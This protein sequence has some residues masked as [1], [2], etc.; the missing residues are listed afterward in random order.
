[1]NTPE[2]FFGGKIA[3]FINQWEMLTSDSW[4][5]DIVKGYKIEF[6]QLPFQQNLPNSIHFNT[7]E[8]NI[9]R[10]EIQKLLHKEVIE[11]TTPCFKNFISNICVR[12]KA[13]GTHRLIL[14]LKYLNED[15]EHIHF[16][17]ET[18]KSVLPIIKRNSWYASVDLKDAYYSVP[19]DK[20]FRKYLCFYWE[21]SLYRFTSLPNGLSSAP[22]VFTKLMKPVFSH[23]R[24][25]GYTNICYIDDILLQGDTYEE[26]LEN[27]TQ[28]TQLVD[29]LGLTIHP[30]KS[31]FEPC[32][33]ITFLGFIINS[34]DMTIRL[35][36]EKAKELSDLCN[37]LSK[38]AEITIRELAQVIGKMVA[39]ESGMEYG[40]LY[41]KSLE[42]EKDKKLKENCGNFEAKIQISNSAKCSLN[43]WSNNIQLCF[44]SLILSEPDIVIKTDS[45]K[46]GWGGVVENT[47]LKTGGFW[48]YEEQQHH[49]NFLE[50]KAA[51]LTIQSFLSTDK[52]KHVKLFMDNSVAVSYL[53]KFGGRKEQLNNLTRHIWFWCIDRNIKL[54]V[55]HLPGNCNTEADS[56]SRNLSV[57]MEW[58]LN[59]AVFKVIE[60]TYGPLFM[61]L[62]ASRLN[63][64]LQTY[65]S[66]LPDPNAIAVDAFSLNWNL[67]IN[68]AFPPFS[69]IAQVLKKLEQDQGQLVLIAPLWT[70]QPWFTKLLQMV[71]AD[72]YLLPVRKNLLMSP[73]DP[74]KLHPIKNLKLA[75]FRLSGKSSDALEYQ[76]T[77]RKFSFHPGD[78]RP[79]NSIGSILQDGCS[80]VVKGKQIRINHLPLY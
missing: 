46:T 27:V 54:S 11:I 56:M 78:N 24:K 33:S 61:D 12:P 3:K 40:P 37:N 48:S 67:N 43:W 70:T 28:T 21:N 50:L 29:N 20:E 58:K 44:K 7:E 22:R 10:Q 18:L 73:T 36:P 52:N 32:T 79:R 62:F 30:I 15:V 9:I 17:M 71:C 31:V 59:T 51:F 63:H 49:I 72:S 35:T 19:V 75:V 26:C 6:E 34:E 14:N 4:I 47:T 41:Y 76:S 66:F 74:T 60:D 13:D 5:L 16:K 1:M 55:F 68:Y 38:R 45:S 65:T 8:C 25:M 64:Q 39:S 57:D 2:N 53:S 77:L 42:I 23:L 69:L 80:F